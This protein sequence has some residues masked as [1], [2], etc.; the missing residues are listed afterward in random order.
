MIC[1]AA[2]NTLNKTIIGLKKTNP[3]KFERSFKIA[4]LHHHPLPIP[5]KRI[6][7][8]LVKTFE[9]KLTVMDN[10]ATFA[11]H[12]N[13]MGI[14][15]IL[16]GHEHM[17][18]Y[19]NVH[20]CGDR[21]LTVVSAGSAS[22][23]E[24]QDNNFNLIKIKANRSVTLDKFIYLPD[25][26]FERTDKPT[27]I[28]GK[29]KPHQK[30]TEPLVL[31]GNTV[32]EVYEQV[33][34]LFANLGGDGYIYDLTTYIQNLSSDPPE[35]EGD[36]FD[37]AYLTH[38][39]K[40]LLKSDAQAIKKKTYYH[41]SHGERIYKARCL[42]EGESID[43]FERV[44][45]NLEHLKND[46]RRAIIAIYNPLIDLQ[47]DSMDHV[48]AFLNV[49]FFIR[50]RKVHAK[51]FYRSQ[52]MCYFWLVNVLEVRDLIGRIV[53]KLNL[54]RSGRHFRLGS[55]SMTATMSFW[56]SVSG[57]LGK[58]VLERQDRDDLEIT[59]GLICNDRANDAI[60]RMIEW[61]EDTKRFYKHRKFNS[62]ETII[63]CCQK[64]KQSRADNEAAERFNRFRK[65]FETCKKSL[66]SLDLRELHSDIE[67]KQGQAVEPIIKFLRSLKETQQ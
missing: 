22:Q 9:R 5:Y 53:A 50:Q 8:G 49:Q 25:T 45:N 64:L 41:Y 30:E 39:A 62:F 65:H 42:H 54:T 51:A 34:D 24:L 48:P 43:Q 27:Q 35:P 38:I 16:H 60:E 15:L 32:K 7:H 40:D 20:Y 56:D 36:K 6:A 52:E 21:S 2:F 46:E 19:Y 13:K 29:A 1:P 10:G 4:V 57:L 12:L 66:E 3:Q 44:Y 18:C 37:I 59:V 47:K 33:K 55:L 23:D 63:S 31:E 14:D 67:N 58:P 28:K 61:L 17:D 26:G 11:N